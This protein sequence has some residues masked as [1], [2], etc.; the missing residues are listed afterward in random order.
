MPFKYMK[1]IS[2]SF[3]IFFV[4]MTSQGAGMPKSALIVSLQGQPCDA[5]IEKCDEFKKVMIET[6]LVPL[7][8]LI[9]DNEVVKMNDCM[10]KTACDYMRS[11][12]A[13]IPASECK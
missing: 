1:T 4:S 10:E 6:C 5:I 9:T 7:P 12:G 3:S 8:D 13:E 11:I 2:L